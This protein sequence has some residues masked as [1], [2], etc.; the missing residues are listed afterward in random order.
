MKQTITRL[1]TMYN[2][3]D[4]NETVILDMAVCTFELK[5]HFNITN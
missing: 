4:Y 1:E 5:I 2:E 3:T